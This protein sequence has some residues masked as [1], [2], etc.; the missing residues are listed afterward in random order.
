MKN[1]SRIIIPTELQPEASAPP[2]PHFDDEATLLTARAVVPLNRVVDLGN[3]RG[4]LVKAAVIVVA[5]FLGAAAA[6]SVDFFQNLRHATEAAVVEPSAP[7]AQGTVSETS[8]TSQ[9]SLPQSGGPT[10]SPNTTQALSAGPQSDLSETPPIN[11]EESRPA[12]NRNQVQEKSARSDVA[13]DR[14]N[15]VGKRSEP[16]FPRHRASRVQRSNDSAQIVERPRD[17]GRI[18][19]IFEGPSPF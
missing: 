13:A 2:S 15:V 19:E 12:T 6:V 9:T 11:A 18:R 17:A 3:T 16:T 8:D 1:L 7:V 14:R 4:Y 5:A 10:V